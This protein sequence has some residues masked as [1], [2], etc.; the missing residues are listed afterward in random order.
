MGTVFQ[1]SEIGNRKDRTGTTVDPASFP[2][3]YAFRI[4]AIK[5]IEGLQNRVDLL[6]IPI[7]GQ[8]GMI[9]SGA[10]YGDTHDEVEMVIP[11]NKFLPTDLLQ[12]GGIVCFGDTA[13]YR[14][15]KSKK[16]GKKK[17]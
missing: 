3:D 11:A 16:K 14:K 1:D 15:K 6:E 5:H 9:T 2:S 12:A 7:P 10:T 8:G 4:W 13:N 17:H